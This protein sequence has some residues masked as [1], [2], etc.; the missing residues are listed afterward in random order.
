MVSAIISGALGDS[1][2]AIAIIGIVALNAG[3]GFYQE[4]NAGKSI[5]ALKKIVA[6]QAKV[7]RNARVISIPA[8]QVVRGDVVILE[9]G[10]LVAADARLLEA[11]A[12]QC[13][14][15]TLTGESEA[16]RKSVQRMEA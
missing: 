10:D 12:L 13:I 3:I 14:E 5:S 15:S 1:V 6:P 7:L 4:Y 16:V 2:D 9:A 11:A 8:S